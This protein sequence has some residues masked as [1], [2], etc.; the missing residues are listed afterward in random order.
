MQMK[1]KVRD[2]CHQIG[3]TICI[4]EAITQWANYAELYV[5]FIKED[6]WMMNSPL[7]LW[8]YCME[9][10]AIIHQVTAR[11]LFQLHGTNSHTSMFGTEADI[12]HL[13]QFGWYEWVYYRDQSASFVPYPKECLG[14]CLG[15]AKNEG[16]MMAQ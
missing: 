5:G 2:F 6:T 16:N 11:K 7:V 1:H 3:T 8:D 4:L 15:S 12:L 9:R 13:C 14:L 10:R